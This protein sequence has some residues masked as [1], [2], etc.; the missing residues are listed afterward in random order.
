[1]AYVPPRHSHVSWAPWAWQGPPTPR[2][3]TSD[4]LDDVLPAFRL[5]QCPYCAVTKSTG[6]YICAGPQ[7]ID[8]CAQSQGTRFYLYSRSR[9]CS[10]ACA[11][12]RLDYARRRLLGL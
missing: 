2:L 5:G 9:W 3:C 10:L 7:N 4:S 6:I 11:L 12:A 8:A 1:A